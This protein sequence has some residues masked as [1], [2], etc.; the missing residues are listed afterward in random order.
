V[1]P[2]IEDFDADIRALSELVTQVGKRQNE[3]EK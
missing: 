3:K 2:R 1:P